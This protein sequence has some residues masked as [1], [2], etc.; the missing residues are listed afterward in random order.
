MTRSVL[1][2]FHPSVSL[3]DSPLPVT[4]EGPEA[5]TPEGL[6]P[7][8]APIFVPLFCHTGSPP[9]FPVWSSVGYLGECV[10]WLIY[11]KG[12]GFS[13]WGCVCLYV[14][15]V[16]VCVWGESSSFPPCSLPSYPARSRYVT[17]VAFLE[18]LDQAGLELHRD[19]L[20]HI[21]E[22]LGLMVCTPMPE[23]LSLSVQLLPI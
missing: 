16:C 9:V 19:V 10:H 21:L 23:S 4:P 14:C 13:A 6:Y 3:S 20:A 2:Q 15:F 5:S 12:L 7:G 18:T 17:L 22:L 8:R 11:V 1:R